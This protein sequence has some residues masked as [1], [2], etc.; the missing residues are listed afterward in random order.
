[1]KYIID[2]PKIYTDKHYTNSMLNKIQILIFEAANKIYPLSTHTNWDSD[3]MFR[4]YCWD[5]NNKHICNIITKIQYNIFT[6]TFTVILRFTED[7]N[8]KTNSLF[9]EFTEEEV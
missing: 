3:W 8:Y 6:E 9:L 7:D 1:M 4:I 2:K 5:S